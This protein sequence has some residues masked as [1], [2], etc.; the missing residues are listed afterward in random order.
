MSQ[1]TQIKPPRIPYLCPS[2]QSVVKNLSHMGK[3]YRVQQEE[4]FK[5]N[6]ITNPATLI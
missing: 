6:G 2:V 3:S 1:N 5:P 4:K